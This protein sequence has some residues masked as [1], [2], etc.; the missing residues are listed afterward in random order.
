MSSKRNSVQ[1]YSGGIRGFSF[2]DVL[3]IEHARVT[4]K[5]GFCKES[6]ALANE[7][8]AAGHKL[9]QYSESGKLP[10]IRNELEKKIEKIIARLKELGNTVDIIENG[11]KRAYDITPPK[12]AD[13]EE[14]KEENKEDKQEDNQE[15]SSASNSA[16]W[17]C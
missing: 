8:S 17:S 16:G 7:L 2:E 6:S 13:V 4:E 14:N 15:G 5:Q 10:K 9:N 12:V 1:F 3:R 11:K